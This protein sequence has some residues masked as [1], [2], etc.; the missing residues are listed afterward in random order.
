MGSHEGKRAG[1]TRSALMRAARGEFAELGLAG[2]RVDRIAE[3]AGVNKERIYGIFGSKDKLFDAVLVDVM[4]EFADTVVPLW[5]SHSAGD[6]VGRLYDYHRERPELLRLLV[7]EALHRGDDAHD[8]DGWRE[9]HSRRKREGVAER[10]GTD[11]P[12]QGALLALALCGIPNWINLVP[13]LR[14]LMLGDRADDAEAIRAFLIP[15]AEGAA[16]AVAAPHAINTLTDPD[17]EGAG[18][19]VRAAVGDADETGAAAPGTNG[20]AARA[21]GA[22]A[23][24]SFNANAVRVEAAALAEGAHTATPVDSGADEVEAAAARL[25]RA[26]AEAEAAKAALGA[27]LRDANTAGASANAL[28]KR[29]AG[30]VSRPVVLKL[31]AD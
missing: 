4:Q 2:A 26:Q 12:F 14:R 18:P 13:Q 20:E 22:P 5:R 19:E 15:L 16:R 9:G 28:A 27:A 29:V 17:E 11:G 24:T 1:S 21:E 23:S 7:W 8:V 30:T 3:A 10:F 25:R 31:L 6:F